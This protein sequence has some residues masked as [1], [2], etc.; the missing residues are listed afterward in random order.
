MEKL[1]DPG[2]SSAPPSSTSG[3][4]IAFQFNGPVEHFGDMVN[5]P[6][7]VFEDDRP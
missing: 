2:G 6:K 5:G 1:H 3:T 7:I 4:G